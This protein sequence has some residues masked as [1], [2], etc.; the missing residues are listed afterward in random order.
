MGNVVDIKTRKQ[1][2]NTE[3][4][5]RNQEDKV[6]VDREL[7]TMV[8]HVLGLQEK[9]LDQLRYGQKNST[10]PQF[11]YRELNHEELKKPSIW[12]QKLGFLGTIYY[13]FWIVIWFGV[14]SVLFNEVKDVF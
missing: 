4:V 10:P 11:V 1:V 14:A 8:D 9:Q 2:E 6:L 3:Q 12:K 5:Y 7:L 13:S